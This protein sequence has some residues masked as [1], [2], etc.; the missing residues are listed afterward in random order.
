MDHLD[1]HYPELLADVSAK[2]SKASKPSK[3]R[4]PGHATTGA[5]TSNQVKG[6]QL[7]MTSVMKASQ[8]I[9]GEI[10]IK[11]L[12]SRMMQI[13]LENAGAEKGCL[14][15]KS[16]GDFRIE[17]E[18][19]IHQEKVQVLQSI[20]LEESPDV[21]VTIIQYVA[22]AK[23]NLVL[24]DAAH[25]GDFTTDPYIMNHQPK[26]LLCAPLIHRNDLSGILYLENTVATGAFTPERLEVL[27]L[28]CS[29]AAISLENANL[30]KQ[31]QDYSKT[32]E[33]KVEERTTELKRSLET[34]KKTQAQLVQSEKMAALGG[35]V[36]GVAHEVNTPIGIAVT[37]AS[38]LE[39]KTQEFVA[40]V[41]SQKLKRSD[42]DSYAKTASDSSNLILKNLSGAV[43]IVQGFKQV[44]V[45]QTSGE[46]RE[47]K[48]KA[49]IEDVLLSLK[50]KLKHTKHVVTVTCP[51][52]LTLKSFPGAFSQIISNLV[53][54]SLIHG[55]EEVEAGEITFDAV[56]EN[57]SI[58]L[59]YRDNGKGM[60]EKT[61]KK[62]FDPFFTTKRSR[63]GSGLGMHIVH[64][65]VTQTL[66][67]TILCE[68]QPGNGMMI[69][70]KV[71]MT[72]K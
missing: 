22:R 38:H 25:Q 10:E 57:G 60:D 68:S 8:V 43:K 16:D 19:H 66:G 37:A 32:L 52:D 72:E 53:M 31:Q 3:D 42:L 48:L 29:Q 41:E 58:I 20:P 24:E 45:D 2:T 65:L 12:L 64:N 33:E 26:S 5:T 14:I 17:A 1:Q 7:D 54:N 62:I 44:A 39:D 6:E 63:G 18:G 51:E 15:L 67:G 61:L 13:I 56:E 69:N 34:I 21:P 71:P 50:P 59:T 9:S 55:F 35:L 11:K 40:K 46:R 49:Y 4:E 28:L 36:A 30:Y 47:F 27:P 23:E 70:M